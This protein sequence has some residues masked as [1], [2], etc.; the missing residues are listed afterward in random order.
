MYFFCTDNQRV[1]NFAAVFI[2]MLY[3]CL[4]KQLLANLITIAESDILFLSLLP[5]V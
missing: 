2:A 4:M 5:S 1:F 3:V